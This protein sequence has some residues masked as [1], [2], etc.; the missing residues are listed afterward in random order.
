[1]SIERVIVLVLDSVGAGAAPDAAAYGDAGAD[2]LGHTAAAAG[3]LVVPTLQQ[4]GLGNLRP[5]EGVPPAAAPRGAFGKMRELSAGKDTQTG[6]WEL[7]GLK[8][9]HPFPT[10]PDGF[11]PAILDPF[12]ARTGRGVLGNKPASGTE[13]L[14]ELGEVHLQTG[15][16]IVYT[17]AD[18][19]FQIAAHTDVVPLEE[20]YRI[21]AIAREILDPY[22]V[23]RVIARPFV[24]A[25]KGAF[26]RTYDR[27]DFGME[28]PAPTVLDQLA[29]AGLPV[30]G[31]G[32]IHDIYA[33]RGITSSIHTEGN[34][35]G[36]AKTQEALGELERGVVLT[37]LVDFDS[38]YGHR[39]NAVGYAECLRA[40]DAELAELLRAL[41]PARDLIMLTADHGTDPTFRGTDHTREFVPI[42]AFG[43]ATAAGV[44]L[45]TRGS[46]ADLGATMAE[47]FGVQP[48][49]FGTSFL[50]EIA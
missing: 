47:I 46:F 26:R 28:P 4:I 11:P 32:K 19:V 13:I 23:G 43:P 49:P 27:R 44:D 48:P 20:L 14:D 9:D 3:G 37:N 24:G 31:V 38:V 41:D 10:F 34:S 25:G 7:A 18:S 40:F 15:A 30:V 1:M 2:T 5:L 29:G 17:S 33:G 50:S 36:M 22:Q 21:C 39:R 16:L 45:G 6:H 42:L 12:R 8:I 35:D